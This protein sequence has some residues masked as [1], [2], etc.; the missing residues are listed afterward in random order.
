MGG[1]V[2]YETESST[3]QREGNSQTEK[4]DATSYSTNLT[5][6]FKSR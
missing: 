6:I 3:F 1:G 2:R 4:F 5:G